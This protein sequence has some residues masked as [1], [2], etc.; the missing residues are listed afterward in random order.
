MRPQSR[1][2]IVRAMSSRPLQVLIAGGG[3]AA[4]EATLALRELAEDRVDVEVL[5][6]E[7]DFVYRAMSVA[8]PFGQG[9]ARRFPLARLADRRAAPPRRSSSMTR[10]RDDWAR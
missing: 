6:P 9:E 8:E 2:A 5:A 10:R 3:V 4:L 1:R 7:D